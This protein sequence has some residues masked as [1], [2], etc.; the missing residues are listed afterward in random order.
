MPKHQR[1]ALGQGKVF[2]APH[3]RSVVVLFD[4]IG[5]QHLGE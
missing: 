2:S 4:K 5:W 1:I 3:L